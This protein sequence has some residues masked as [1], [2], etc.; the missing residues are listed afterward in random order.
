MNQFELSEEQAMVQET[1]RKLVDDV[2]AREALEHDEHGR[3]VQTAFARLAELGLFGVLVGEDSGGAGFGHL[4]FVVALE[5]LARGC[6]S[7]ARTFAVQ[8]GACAVALEGSPL[9]DDRLDPI[10]AGG[11]VAAFVGPEFGIVAEPADSGFTLRGRA[12]IVTAAAVAETFLVVA[13]TPDGTPV[14]A[15]PAADE[16]TREAA[17]TLGFRASAPGSVA[18]DGVRVGD[19]AAVSGEAARAAGD[20]ADLVIQIAGAA[21]AVGAARAA[22]DLAR[23][24]AHDRSAFGKPLARFQAVQRK[25]VEARRL[26]EA[27]RH[28]TWHAARLADAGADAVDSARFARLSAVEA[29]TRASD[30]A[31]QIHGGYG[32]TVE[33]HVERLYRDAKMLEVMD[34]GAEWLLD[35]LAASTVSERR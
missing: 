15:C 10:L 21:I 14:I 2:V 22:I 4:A 30:E 12:P 35:S 9:A 7:T 29:A 17:A 16:L 8:A 31:I 27:A 26:T 24:Y 23:G 34:R 3:F 5:E 18:L 28:L 6:G 13:R 33:Y 20:R 1:V 11:A 32:F 25:L 19:D